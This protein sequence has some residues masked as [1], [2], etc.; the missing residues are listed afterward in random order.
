[1]DKQKNERKQMIRILYV[2]AGT[3]H[4]GGTEAYI[5]NYYRHMDKS[6]I[7]IDFIVHGYEIGVYDDEIKALGGKI[8]HVPTQTRNPVKN[9]RMIYGICK[10]GR[11][12]I[13]HSHMDVKGYLALKI[14]KNCGIPI[15]IAHSHNTSY[16]TKNKFKLLLNEYARKKL[17]SVATHCFAC[18]NK[19]GLWLFGRENV[20]RIQVIPN[21]ID[22]DKFRYNEN[23][24]KQIRNKLRFVDSDIVI[25]HI[26]RFEYQK[27]HEYLIEVFCRL[28]K[29]SD[30]YRLVMIGDGSLKDKIKEMVRNYGLDSF[31]I[32]IDACANVNEYYNIFDLFC[33]PS[34]FEGLSFVMIEAQCNG[35]KC[36]TSD[37]TSIESNVTGNVKY[38]SILRNSLDTWVSEI[39]NTDFT[40]DPDAVGKV[41]DSGYSISEAAESL[42]NKYLQFMKEADSKC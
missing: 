5:M 42:Q 4:R 38:I 7:Q 31:I 36:I 2:L 11:Y 24:R 17:P 41:I 12:N 14:A 25:G 39:L 28:C 3:F 21:A 15:R 19:A 8:Y 22:T 40:R 20:N 26:G 18:S 23:I 33:M 29:I 16:V 37:A 6:K 1:M 9:I 27:N 32:F 30:R 10:S 35:L 34:H 13:I